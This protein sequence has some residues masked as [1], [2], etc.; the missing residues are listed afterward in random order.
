METFSPG[1]IADAGEQN[2]LYANVSTGFKAGGFYYGP[3]GFSIYE[4]ELVTSYVIGSKNR[5]FDNHFQ[6][7]IEGFYLNY[8][9]QQVSFIKL[10]GTPAFST[11]V[12]E[13]AGK[14]HAYGLDIDSQLLVTPTTRLNFQAQYLR[15]KYD[16]FTILTLAPPPAARTSCGVSAGTPPQ[17]IVDCSGQTTLRSPKWTLVGG[18]EQGL[19]LSNG[20]RVVAEANARYESSY[21]TDVSYLPEG[22]ANGSTRVNLSLGYEAPRNAFSIRA[23]V[24]NLTDE[25]SIAATTMGNSYPALPVFA[26]RLLAPRTYG[27]RAQVNF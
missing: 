10:V 15:S 18:I 27:I 3:P 1:L 12:T 24:E 25:V 26:T 6:F 23:Y 2:L 11:L 7:N 22:V 16:E 21:Q 20:G 9:N 17:S 8:T 13:N 14:S 4:P 5:F 19:P